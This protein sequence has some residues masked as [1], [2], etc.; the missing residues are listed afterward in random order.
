MVLTACC[1]WGLAWWTASPGHG[2]RTCAPRCSRPA[3]GWWAAAWP[4]AGGPW[5]A[6]G[7]QGNVPQRH[8][9]RRHVKSS[10]EELVKTKGRTWLLKI[11]TYLMASAF[12]TGNSLTAMT[13][14]VWCQNGNKRTK[15]DFF[16]FWKSSKPTYS[17]LG[18]FK[19]G[20]MWLMKKSF[21]F[22]SSLACVIPCCW[23]I[24]IKLSWVL[25]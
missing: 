3:G 4:A 12:S 11:M 24:G 14:G 17:P 21:R 2:R 18:D 10:V 20:R 1:C 19:S 15:E 5:E 22:T 23:R 8:V 6:A 16:S 25:L 9:Q 13:N 7:R